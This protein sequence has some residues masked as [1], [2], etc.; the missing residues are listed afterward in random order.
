MGTTAERKRRRATPA[1]AAVAVG[2]DRATWNCDY[3]YRADVAV[4]G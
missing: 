2:A 3:T 4:D 1:D